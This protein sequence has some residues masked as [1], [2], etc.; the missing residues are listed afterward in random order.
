MERQQ[1]DRDW[2]R[3]PPASAEERVLLRRLVVWYSVLYTLF[4]F[5]YIV[6]GHDRLLVDTDYTVKRVIQVALE[7]VIAN[8]LFLAAF[9]LRNAP[10][11]PWLWIMMPLVVLG[12]ALS[13]LVNVAV[14]WGRT[15]DI[16]ITY[17]TLWGFSN[18]TFFFAQLFVIGVVI[19]RVLLSAH[20]SRIQAVEL[21]EAREQA[22]QAQLAML[23]YQLNPHF[24]FNTLNAISTLIVTGRP[25]QAD[26]M[27]AKLSGFLRESLATRPN[28][29]T[30]LDAELGL[31]QEYL[32]IEAVRFGEKLKVD[33]ACD[34]AAGD[35]LVPSL[36]LQPLVENS[37][38]YAVGPS[39][40]LVTI[41]IDARLDGDDLVMLVSDDGDGAKEPTQKGTGV[42]LANVRQRLATTY[43]ERAA[44][45]AMPT[46]NGF[47]AV[48]RLP[49]THLVT[50][51][52]AAE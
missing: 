35:V 36:I 1:Q 52:A 43:G 38:K 9:R 10:L 39:R 12:G 45:E 4:F 19:L 14:D 7:L 2:R 21:V 11:A 32:E 13:T 22:T 18:W 42:G 24:L 29:F 51:K 30:T 25:E 37:V 44:F 16:R 48:I 41:R 46:E 15:D 34:P 33:F 47:L 3:P 49:A 26:E 5:T 28:D 27:L 17:D 40:R 6:G 20:S 31:I 50:L 23:R 8:G